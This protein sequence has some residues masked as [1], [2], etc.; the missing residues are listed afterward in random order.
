MKSQMTLIGSRWEAKNAAKW[1][2]YFSHEE[3]RAGNEEVGHIWGRAVAVRKSRSKFMAKRKR[4]L[5]VRKWKQR[6]AT[7]WKP[8][9]SKLRAN[10]KHPKRFIKQ[11]NK[12]A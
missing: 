12:A 11:V 3:P 8:F 1:G 10:V 2:W 6:R 9:P 7:G 4:A 5:L